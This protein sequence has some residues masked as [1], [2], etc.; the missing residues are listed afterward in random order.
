MPEEGLE[1]QEIKEQLE[2][3]HERAEAAKER[4][5]KGGGERRGPAWVTFLSLTTAFIAAL[6]AV[7]SL[8]AGGLANEGILLKSE[9]ILAESEL[10]DTWGE[11][12]ARNM[13][14]YLFDTQA[15]LM[16]PD[17]AADATKHAERERSE[18]SKFRARAEELRGKVEGKNE[19]SERAMDRHETF[20]RAVTIFQIAIAMSAIAALTRRKWL[21]WASLAGGAA[22]V[23]FLVV[24][25]LGT[26][27]GGGEARPA[28]SV[29]GETAP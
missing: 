21:W 16:P 26:H 14:A 24:G 11:Y 23:A 7:A 1:T 17:K 12:Q 10:T 25:F 4:E 5:E 27:P 19:E 18:A 20:A 29:H 22:G 3:S 28:S 8:Q 15:A 6:A 9:A 2:E 13:K